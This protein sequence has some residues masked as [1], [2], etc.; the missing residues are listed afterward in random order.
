M[1]EFIVLIT[2]VRRVEEEVIVT[3]NAESAKEAKELVNERTDPPM[4]E[5][6]NTIED[7]NS[8]VLFQ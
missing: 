7:W 8:H 6:K 1:A 4:K 2:R 5:V 3:V